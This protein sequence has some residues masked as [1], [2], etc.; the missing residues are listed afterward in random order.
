MSA[1]PVKRFLD[2]CQR[3][4]VRPRECRQQ[5]LGQRGKPGVHACLEHTGSAGQDSP[6]LRGAGQFGEDRL[7]ALAQ[8]GCLN[9]MPIVAPANDHRLGRLAERTQRLLCGRAPGKVALL[10][11]DPR[12][13]NGVAWSHDGI[14]ATVSCLAV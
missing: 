3:R 5:R 12:D 9:G 4:R 6:I 13:E 2:G 1:N 7:G 10:G 8:R 14:T 11:P